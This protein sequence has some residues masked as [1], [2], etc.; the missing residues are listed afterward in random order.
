MSNYIIAIPSYNR[1]DVISNKTL[2]T[3]HEGNVSKNKIFIF[4][5]NKEQYKLYEENVDK[6]LYHKIVIGKLG[7]TNQRIFISK[8][9]PIGQYIVSLDDDIEEVSKLRGTDKLVRIKDL[10]QFFIDAY[11]LLK[12]SGLYIWGIYPVRNPFFMKNKISYDLKFIIGMMYGYIN[13]HDKNL[14]PSTSIE[15]RE[16]YE[17]SVLYYKMDGGVLRFN[18]INPKTKFNAEGGVGKDRL[19]RNKKSAEY[20]VSKYPDIFSLK[21]RKNG[22]P[23][24]RMNK[25]K[26]ENL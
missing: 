21:Y 20:L 14:Y 7:I 17:M 12:E 3:L 1:Y 11:K 4:V 8:Y 15:T 13:R 18:N 5:A 9:F 10:N 22:M 19:E 2:K 24:V 25:L 6:N 16:D 26:K 23:E